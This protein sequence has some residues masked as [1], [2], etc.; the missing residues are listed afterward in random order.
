VKAASLAL[1]AAL[2]LVATGC[3]ELLPPPQSAQKATAAYQG[4]L[5]ET[6]AAKHKEN[7]SPEEFNHIAKAFYHDLDINAQQR[8]DNLIT[9]SCAAPGAR[10]P[11]CY[12]DGFLMSIQNIGETGHF[13]LKVCS[14][15]GEAQSNES[16]PG[17]NA[18]GSSGL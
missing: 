4:R 6:C 2:A 10:E 18:H 9:R 5:A 8:A 15:P 7:L 17:G 13:T 1:L 14:E 12:N 11:G 16:N 3:D